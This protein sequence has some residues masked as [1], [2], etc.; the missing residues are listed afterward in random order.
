MLGRRC[1]RDR[2]GWAALPRSIEVPHALQAQ[3]SGEEAADEEETLQGWRRLGRPWRQDQRTNREAELEAQ[4]LPPPAVVLR[5][6]D[7]SVI[8]LSVL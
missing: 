6:S 7:G 5:W 1:A 8:T 3:V 4:T 2:H